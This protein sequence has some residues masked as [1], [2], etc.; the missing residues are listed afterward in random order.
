MIMHNVTWTNRESKSKCRWFQLRKTIHAQKEKVLEEQN[1]IVV[2]AIFEICLWIIFGFFKADVIICYLFLTMN[3]YY[4][5][6]KKGIFN[7]LKL[8]CWFFPY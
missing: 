3:I 7:F 5:N 2:M 1:E 8:T 4:S 6:K